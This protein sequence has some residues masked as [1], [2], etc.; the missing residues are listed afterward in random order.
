MNNPRGEKIK[1]EYDPEAVKHAARLGAE[2]GADVVKVSYTGSPESF[3]EVVEGSHVPVLIA[4]GPK[5]GSDRAIL[6]MVKGAMK[7]GAAGVSI[8]RNVFQHQN[9]T[10]IVAA[11]SM[12]VHKNTTVDEALDYLTSNQEQGR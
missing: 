6:E 7:A 8:G 3:R 1:D 11:L 12:V 9:P 4:G 5:M 2:L 10:R